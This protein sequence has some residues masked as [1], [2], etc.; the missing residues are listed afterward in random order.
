MSLQLVVDAHEPGGVL[1]V[2]KAIPALAKD[3]T[4]IKL[5]SMAKRAPNAKPEAL[6]PWTGHGHN[7]AQ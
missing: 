2:V 5:A 4:G 7:M 3:T 6:E 1:S